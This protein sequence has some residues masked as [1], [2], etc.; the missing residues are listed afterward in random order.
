MWLTNMKKDKTNQVIKRAIDSYPGGL[1]FSAPDGRVILSNQKMN[2]LLLKLTGHTMLN[3]EVAWEELSCVSVTAIPKRLEQPWLPKKTRFPGECHTKQLFFQ[4]SDDSVWQFEYTSLDETTIQIEA[5]DITRL[6]RLSEELYENSI[7]LREMQ[8]RQ[9]SLLDNIVQ[10]NENKEIL[11][12]KMRIHD[13][14]GQVLLATNRAVTERSLSENS[15]L[16]QE[17]W[18]NSVQ[19]FLNV[20]SNNTEND[21]AIQNELLKVAELIGCKIV[22]LGEL[23]T[24][25]GAIHLLYAA[26]REVLTNAVRHANA[27]ELIVKSDIKDDYFCAEISDN[28][29][30]VVSEITE[31]TGLSALRKRLEQNG[32]SMSILCDRHVTLSIRIPNKSQAIKKGGGK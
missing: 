4:F 18:N 26:I 6:Y 32:A 8:E 17:N 3:A 12:A 14:F 27:T 13:E 16:L 28:G 7:R 9:R 2:D 11:S 23:P 21:A 20:S 22:F 31:G 15:E 19:N 10:V 1:C 5:A 25:T 30:T 24:D 29:D